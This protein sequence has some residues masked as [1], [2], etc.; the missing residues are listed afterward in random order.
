MAGVQ[1]LVFF[2]TAPPYLKDLA[3]QYN[4]TLVESKNG[5]S[6]FQIL[7]RK[8]HG[9]TRGSC[10]A[11]ETKK[12]GRKGTK[13]DAKASLG[14]QREYLLLTYMFNFHRSNTHIASIH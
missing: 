4:M 9:R 10:Q 8:Q 11:T 1:R 5:S 14:S 12:A 6:C 7:S 13:T 3:Q 2:R